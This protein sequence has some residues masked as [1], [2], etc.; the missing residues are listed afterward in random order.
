MGGYIYLVIV[1]GVVIDNSNCVLVNLFNKKFCS[2]YG[3]LIFKI[4]D[5]VI[6]LRK[7]EIRCCKMFVEILF[8]V[9]F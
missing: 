4:G 7:W 5:F 1:S 2:V 9:N 3:N 8:I 6:Y